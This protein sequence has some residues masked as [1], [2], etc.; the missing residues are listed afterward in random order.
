M[1]R[2]GR[3]EGER[4]LEGE[5]RREGERE[6]LGER[7]MRREEGEK[8]YKKTFKK[9]TWPS[10]SSLAEGALALAPKLCSSHVL[11]VPRS[12]RADVTPGN[13]GTDSHVYRIG[14][15]THTRTHARVCVSVSV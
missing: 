7:G 15:H 10:N 1:E 5:G 6:L 13:S 2:E 8:K 12:T 11:Q 14:M 3:K 9:S 4:E